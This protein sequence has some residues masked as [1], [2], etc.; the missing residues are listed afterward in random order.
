MPPTHT[1]TIRPMSIKGI[2]MFLYRKQIFVILP[3]HFSWLNWVRKCCSI[4]A[5]FCIV[6]SCSTFRPS[7]HAYCQ[8]YQ[9]NSLTFHPFWQFHSMESN[10]SSSSINSYTFS[11]IGS[12]TSINLI[13]T[14]Y[15]IISISFHFDSILDI[16]DCWVPALPTQPLWKIRKNLHNWQTFFRTA[17]HDSCNNSHM[18]FH[19]FGLFNSN[20]LYPF[21]EIFW[22][23]QLR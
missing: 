8:L 6:Y 2:S 21:L 3:F 13:E 11:S 5:N 7:D 23:K 22:F 16:I 14:I 18:W 10:R 9:F 17:D 20:A 19:L 4:S 15:L 1:P 12:I